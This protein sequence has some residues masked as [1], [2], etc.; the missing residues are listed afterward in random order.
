MDDPF[1]GFTGW[2]AAIEE[3]ASAPR[4]RWKNLDRLRAALERD[5]PPALLRHTTSD[6]RRL[7][8]VAEQAAV[9]QR[10]VYE[11]LARSLDQVV[12][13]EYVGDSMV[14]CTLA[15]GRA[16][17]GFDGGVAPPPD[18]GGSPGAGAA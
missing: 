11:H 12:A 9:R 15:S 4:P 2:A 8:T 1:D 6:G 13:V 16:V 17:I 14:V 10:L 3:W 5:H 18:R 7:E